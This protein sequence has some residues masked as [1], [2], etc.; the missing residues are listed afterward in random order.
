MADGAIAADQDELAECFAGA[1][2][3]EQPEEAFDG[4]VD[5]FV[6][7]FFA[8]GAMN[9]VGDAGHGAAD[10]VAVGDIASDDFEAIVGI[11]RAIVAESAN[12]DVGEVVVTLIEDATNEIGAD[13]AGCAGDE[14]AFHE[15]FL[16]LS[17]EMLVTLRCEETRCHVMDGNAMDSWLMRT[18]QREGAWSLARM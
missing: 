6:G 7:R 2:F 14:D 9:D 5:Y 13:F 12:G 17:F 3:F 10:D 15:G 4:D 11:E 8:G 1:A 18:G 16:F